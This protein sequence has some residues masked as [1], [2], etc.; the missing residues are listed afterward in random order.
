MI[1]KLEDGLYLNNR[2][3]MWLASEKTLSTNDSSQLPALIDL[4]KLSHV[5]YQT[6]TMSLR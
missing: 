3:K 4:T 6:N 5:F 1:I 2:V